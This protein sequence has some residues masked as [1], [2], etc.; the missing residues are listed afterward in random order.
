[1]KAF[2]FPGHLASIILVALFTTACATPP[3][4]RE[5]LAEF[6]EIND[7][8]EP[9]N[10]KFFAFN[11]GLDSALFKPLAKAYL[12]L[13]EPARDGL[14]NMIGNV[15]APV[16]LA[17]D[18]LQG[19]FTRASTT[20]GRFVINST[21]GLGGMFDVAANMGMEHH[22]EDFGQTLGTW[23]SPTGPYVVIPI[24]GPSSPRA[25]VGNVADSFLDPLTYLFDNQDSGLEYMLI[26]GGVEGIDERSRV[27]D[28]LDDIETSSL[29]FYA[30]IRSLYRQR[31]E[32][33]V[34]NGEK[35]DNVPSG[36]FMTYTDSIQSA[37]GGSLVQ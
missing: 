17:N 4:D 3:V 37:G 31:R 8:L 7:P 2:H 23:G 1:M 33:E 30:T 15:R 16:N 25:L 19:E 6:Q 27:I 26:R 22:S 24:L 35:D 14:H 34:L 18:L 5:A 9:M 11:R 21:I 13:P 29:D 36:S 32:A 28:V 12:Y 10:R 20:L